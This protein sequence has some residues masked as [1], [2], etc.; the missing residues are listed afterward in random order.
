[1]GRNKAFLPFISADGSHHWIDQIISTLKSLPCD[2]VRV[3]GDHPGYQ[4]IPDRFSGLGPLGGLASV[5]PF[6]DFTHLIVVPV[7]MPRLQP[8]HLQTLLDSVQDADA[9]VFKN[10]P[11]PFACRHS[12]RL[13]E[14]LDSLC[15]PEVPSRHRSF[16]TLGSCLQ[17]R[18]IALPRDWEPDLRNFNTPDDLLEL[19]A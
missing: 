6:E 19:A 4:G 18:E 2:Q 7:D 11:L 8:K 14:T 9:A 17:T 15:A 5:L 10:Y 12:Q 1:M 16:K 13:I 3:S